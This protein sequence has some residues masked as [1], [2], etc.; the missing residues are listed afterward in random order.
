MGFVFLLDLLN[1]YVL[2]SLVGICM[3]AQMFTDV[4]QN[5]KQY[6]QCC[7]LAKIHFSFH[8]CSNWEYKCRD[9]LFSNI[10]AEEQKQM[11]FKKL[12][13]VWWGGVGQ[14]N[15]LLCLIKVPNAPKTQHRVVQDV[16]LTKSK[17]A[18]KNG[19]QMPIKK[20]YKACHCL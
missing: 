4:S 10:S 6:Y 13:I 11:L 16:A 19:H 12:H 5:K 15:N 14:G 18:L 9:D 2:K 17:C 7:F 3:Q 1:K 8:L 20:L